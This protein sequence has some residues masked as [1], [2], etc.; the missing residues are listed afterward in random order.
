M[1]RLSYFLGNYYPQGG[2]QAFADELALRFEERG[3]HILMSSS[4]KRILVRRQTAY[5][6]EVETA[7]VRTLRRVYA[8]VVVSNSDLL[9]TYERML[10]PQHVDPDQIAAL[11]RL[12]PTH[13]CF[14]T[15]IGLKGVP[16]EMLREVAG[17]H[18]ASWDSDKVATHSFKIFVPTLYEPAMAPPGCH[19]IIVQK[20]TNIDYCAIDDWSAHKR[21][22]EQYIMANLERLMPGFSE[23]MVVCLSAS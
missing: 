13:P 16:T 7:R 2:S 5:G 12:R 15:H 9:L 14:L 21:A 6:V 1:L 4:V 19:I 17:Y 3:G 11:K 22:V 8:G 20:L 23:R 18:W 10:G